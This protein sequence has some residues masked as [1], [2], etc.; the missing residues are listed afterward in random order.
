MEVNGEP[1]IVFINGGDKKSQDNDIKTAEKLLK[2]GLSGLR[3]PED[4][5]EA[6]KKEFKDYG[7]EYMPKPMFA[8]VSDEELLAAGVPAEFLVEVRSLLA[9]DED[10][11]LDVADRVPVGASHFLIDVALKRAAVSGSVRIH[12]KL[13]EL[14][15]KELLV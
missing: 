10:G 9:G 12:C 5:S 14:K 2:D 8:D 13:I 11:L 7:A 15:A 3:V 4:E 1:T 6:T